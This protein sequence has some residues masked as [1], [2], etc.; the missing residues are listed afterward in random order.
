M[1][2]VLASD[3]R[4]A[5]FDHWWS[6]IAHNL[7]SLA[8]L[9][10]HHLVVYRSIE[11]ANRIFVTI[12]VRDR[13][14]L[15]ALLSSPDVLTWFDDSGVEDLPPVFAGEIVQKLD[16][17]DSAEE[18]P[19]ASPVIVAGIVR[20]PDFERFWQRVQ[21]DLDRIR[22]SGVLRYWTY[23]AFDDP[24]EVMILQEVASEREASRWLRH[25]EAAA[26]WMSSAGVGVYPPLFIGRLVQSIGVPPVAPTG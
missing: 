13:G 2:L 18:F 3:Y 4:V 23:R 12:G 8:R 26:E 21:A 6:A 25:P 9:S 22:D 5:D 16:F 24:N 10:A 11:D 20:I 7:S 19:G 14:P 17:H 15:A 1:S